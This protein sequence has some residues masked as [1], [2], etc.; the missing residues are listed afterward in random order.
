MVTDNGINSINSR[1][2]EYKKKTTPLET[3]EAVRFKVD[4]VVRALT[5]EIRIEG[6][7]DGWELA[8]F[9]EAK[10]YF[11]AWPGKKVG[12]STGLLAV[13]DSPDKLAALLAPEI[14]AV[15]ARHQS[16][17]FVKSLHTSEWWAGLG[18][19]MLGMGNKP[20][21]P[22]LDLALTFEADDLGQEL[23]A[24]AGF[25][26]NELR[27]VLNDSTFPGLGSEQL[28]SLRARHLEAGFSK[29]S[30]LYADTLVSRGAGRCSKPSSP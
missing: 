24:K 1:E 21:A 30:V 9:N 16:E 3:N 6:Q 2:F 12:V 20:P 10:S 11:F 8:V 27:I 18:K 22:K 15:A 13:A 28:R 14:A 19:A 5:E 25:D 7:R 26:P 29:I 23:M 4:C 17:Y